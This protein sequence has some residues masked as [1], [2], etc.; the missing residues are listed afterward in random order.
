MRYR[1]YKIYSLV[2]TL[3]FYIILFAGCANKAST[4]RNSCDMN[5]NVCC[6]C[7]ATYNQVGQVAE[8]KTVC[9]PA[10]KQ[11]FYATWTNSLITIECKR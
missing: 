4:E 10:E 7:I 6:T 11:A 3:F 8:T 9:T 5:D 1:Q 2:A